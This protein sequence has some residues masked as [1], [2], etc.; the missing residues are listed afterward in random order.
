MNFVLKKAIKKQ[1]SWV[2]SMILLSLAFGFIHFNMFAMFLMGISGF[3][4]GVWFKNGALGQTSVY[5]LFLGIIMF[6]TL[7]NFE[8][9]NDAA[10]NWANWKWEK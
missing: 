9:L 1:I 7:M 8:E 10:S 6:V 5:A 3:L 4:L 2:L